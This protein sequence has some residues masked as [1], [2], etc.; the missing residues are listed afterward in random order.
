MVLKNSVLFVDDDPLILASIR[1]AVVDENYVPYFTPSAPEALAIMEKTNISVVVTDLCMP[2]MDGIAL[3]KIAKEKHPDTQKIVLSGY[4]QI[5]QILDSINEGDI[6]K[7][8][9]KPWDMG[10]L[11]RQIRE[12]VAFYELKKEKDELAKS[13]ERSNHAYKNVFKMMDTRLACCD[14]DFSA[15]KEILMFTFS[16]IKYPSH[17]KRGFPL[18]EKICLAFVTSPPSYP[19]VFNLQQIEDG[20][21]NV[22]PLAA[23]SGKLTININDTKCHGTIRF[24]LFLFEVLGVLLMNELLGCNITTTASEGRVIVRGDLKV[25]VTS[26]NE[27]VSYL[28]FLKKLS[29]QYDHVFHIDQYADHMDITIEKS[30]MIQV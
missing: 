20:I 23:V 4:A 8:I 19:T 13:L 12:A 5:N 18:C 27:L 21:L 29:H 16:Q 25:G 2:T 30:Y 9:T 6:Q 11:L 26:S 10:D 1:R 24:L 28:S 3:L 7:Y 17:S 14:K 22:M 15:I